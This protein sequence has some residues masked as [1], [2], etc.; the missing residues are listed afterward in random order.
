MIVSWI[1]YRS[2]L[3]EQDETPCDLMDE[4]YQE[5]SITF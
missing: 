4:L 5:D 3:R 1:K 2:L